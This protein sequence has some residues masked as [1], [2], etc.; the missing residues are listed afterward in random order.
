[1]KYLF[2]AAL[3]VALGLGSI[4]NAY[5]VHSNNLAEPILLAQ[6]GGETTF[7]RNSGGETV[8]DTN[9]G[10]ETGRCQGVCIRNPI[11]ADN[12]QELFQALIDIVLVFAIPIIVFFII[13][14]GFLYVTA[15]G[16]EATIQKAHMAL[17][18]AIIGGLL[19]LGARVLINVVAGTVD[20]ITN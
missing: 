10:G 9:I 14:A 16:N 4:G 6:I 7:D 8:F 19:I 11:A 1:M 17:L 3:V 20:S 12:I 5:A 18:Y 15:R 2:F 13:Y